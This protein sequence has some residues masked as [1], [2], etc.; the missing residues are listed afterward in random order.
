MHN[1][2]ADK[3]GSEVDEDRERRQDLQPHES[4]KQPDVRVAEVDSIGRRHY[5]HAKSVEHEKDESK[6]RAHVLCVQ[7]A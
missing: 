5:G 7:V 3:H 6:T 4:E 2:T 1:K